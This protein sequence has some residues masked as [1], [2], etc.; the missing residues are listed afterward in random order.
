MGYKPALDAHRVA[1]GAKK[2]LG[3]ALSPW[4]EMIGIKVVEMFAEAIPGVIIQLMAIASTPD[5]EDISKAALF[6]IA[7]SALTTGFASASISYDF[8]TNVD[9][10][11]VEPAFYGYVP[12]KARKRTL[13]FASSL[14]FSAGMLTIR[15]AT[16]VMLWM[17]DGR[18]SLLHFC[19]L[20]PLSFSQIT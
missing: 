14:L 18:C 2:E 12:A 16:I 5:G 19:R 13:V 11:N 3:G 7:V 15:C 1:T 20:V 6:S 4:V 17:V 9:M 8:D 10:R